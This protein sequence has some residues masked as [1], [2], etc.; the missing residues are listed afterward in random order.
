MHFERR[1]KIK[2]YLYFNIRTNIRTNER[3]NIKTNDR[4]KVLPYKRT[5]ERKHELG[6]ELWWPNMSYTL[7]GSSKSKI[8][9]IIP[10]I[11]EFQKCPP[12]P[13]IIT[14]LWTLFSSLLKILFLLRIFLI[15]LV[16]TKTVER[17]CF[18]KY[19][20]SL[21]KSVISFRKYQFLSENLNWTEN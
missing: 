6:N 4:T 5:Y 1:S 21:E 16:S 14:V 9:C 3:T 15:K 8:I 20:A 11:I 2:N 18:K 12:P 17:D 7:N 10:R 19:I 13:S